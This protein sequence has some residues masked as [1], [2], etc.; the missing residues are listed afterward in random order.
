MIYACIFIMLLFIA[1]TPLEGL[2]ATVEIKTGI[3]GPVIYKKVTSFKEGRLKAIVPQRF[4]FSCGAASLATILTYYF[5][6]EVSEREILDYILKEGDIEKIKAKGLSLLELKRY[7]EKA[8]YRA[9]GYRV[10]LEVLKKLKVPGI[11]LISTRGY[12]HFVVLKGVAKDRAYIADPALGNRVMS[13]K[14]LSKTWN[15]VIFVLSGPKANVPPAFQ[16]TGSYA[17]VDRFFTLHD[18]GIKNF[19][20][21][22]EEF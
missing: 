3:N 21:Y 17:P 1:G 18:L 15:D 22:P 12:S 16:M 5:G 2:C 11:I 4:D 10:E 8:G 20:V 9:D 6:R 14:D 19:F 13:L 7:A